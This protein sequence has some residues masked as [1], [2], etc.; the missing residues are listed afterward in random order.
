[1]TSVKN[2]SKEFERKRGLI[3]CGCS[4]FPTHAS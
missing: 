3:G 2:K 1:M 4:R